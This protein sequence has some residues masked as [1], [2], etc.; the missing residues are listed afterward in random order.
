MGGT[1][2]ETI[3]RENGEIIKMAR[4][5]G[6]YNW[7]FHSKEFNNGNID[8]AIDD[9]I[10]AF[11]EMKADY[12]SGE[13][14]EYNMSGVYG[15]CNHTAPVSYGLVVID[16]QNKKIHSMQGYDSP[17]GL[18]SFSF[19]LHTKDDEES[20]KAYKYLVENNLYDVYDY[21][22]KYLGDI[23]SVFGA[24]DTFNVIKKE[25]K[26]SMTGIPSLFSFFKTKEYDASDL[27]F[28]PKALKDFEIIDYSEDASGLISMLSA[29]KKDGFEFNSNEIKMWKEHFD[30]YD[31]IVGYDSKFT[32]EEID[33]MSEED[34]D[35]YSEDCM[36]NYHLDI[37]KILNRNKQSNKP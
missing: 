17:G 26:N 29:L 11:M 22:N 31:Q 6:A 24:K 3:R 19:N 13:P 1:V 20:I 9:H 8:K 23:H 10:K 35:K 15:W 30:D 36:T 14:Y 34:Y 21:N 27:I 7:M 12:E 28:F 5:T 37:D 16:I 32:Q 18:H 33:E 2:A 25:I 4:K